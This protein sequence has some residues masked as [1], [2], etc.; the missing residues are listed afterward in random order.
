MLAARAWPALT[1]VN[2]E[3]TPCRDHATE[4]LD[5]GADQ[6]TETMRRVYHGDDDDRPT[7]DGG[8]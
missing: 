6:E 7:S 8:S 5:L 3:E 1:P 2:D 4:T